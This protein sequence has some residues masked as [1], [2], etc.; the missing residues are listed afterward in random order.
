MIDFST[1]FTSLN[2]PRLDRDLLEK[3]YLFAR[4]KH[5]GQKR[6]ISK[7]P[8][9]SHPIRVSQLLREF[10]VEVIAAGLLHDVLEDTNTSVGE[11]RS[12]FG[13]IICNFVV[14]MTKI[15]NKDII[16]PLRSASKIDNRVLLIK[17]AD[18]MDNLGDGI[19]KMSRHTQMKYLSESPKI[20]D[21]AK[22]YDINTFCDEI[23]AKLDILR[24]KVRMQNSPKE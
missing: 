24:Y 13:D 10:E 1:Y 4:E 14:G 15:A 8:Y 18:R 19:L 17:L 20:L 22:E 23:E 9:F 16:T 5:A 6:K 21:L 11:I 12:Q 7:L 2:N 3:V